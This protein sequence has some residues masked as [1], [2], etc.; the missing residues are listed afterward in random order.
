MTATAV[1]TNGIG[2]KGNT[3]HLNLTTPIK[4]QPYPPIAIPARKTRGPK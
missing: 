1:K 4:L 2:S 3:A